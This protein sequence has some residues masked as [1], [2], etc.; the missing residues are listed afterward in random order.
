MESE[1]GTDAEELEFYTDNMGAPTASSEDLGSD[2]ECASTTSHLT[3]SLEEIGT[4]TDDAN[5][6]YINQFSNIDVSD[7]ISKG[8]ALKNQLL[9]WDYLLEC[10]IKIQK[11]LIDS[12]KYPQSDHLSVLKESRPDVVEPSLQQTNE[13]LSRLLDCL[14]AID[15]ALNSRNEMMANERITPYDAVSAQAIS[16]HVSRYSTLLPERHRKM[17]DS[18]GKIIE[19][20]YQKTRLTTGALKH[21]PLTGL[22][23]SCSQQIERILSDMDR[24]V[25]RTQIKRS[26]YD[27]VG[28]SHINVSF[29][30][31]IVSNDELSTRIAESETDPEIFDDDDFYHQMLREFIETKSLNGSSDPKVVSDKW[32]QIQRLRNKIKRKVDTKAS[33]GRRIRYQ[34]HSKLVNFMAPV[35][36][37]INGHLTDEAKDQLFGSLF[38]SKPN[39]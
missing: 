27:I 3:S 12:N 8:N 14:L 28:K 10:R 32:I 15:S 34:V 5:D 21:K 33:K 37:A 6:D 22:E 11:L 31:P 1:G 24:L 36:R 18:R 23:E 9:I 4:N 7:Q 2:N 30:E 38:A 13:S 17:R 25:R 39:L 20:W 29:P 35:T 16:D 26:F 19:K